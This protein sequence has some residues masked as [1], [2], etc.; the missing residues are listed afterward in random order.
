MTVSGTTTFSMTVSE[1]VTEARGLLGIQA[2]EEPL[3]AHELQQGIRTLNMMLKA[4]QADGVQAWTLT[5][6]TFTL[7]QA[8]ADYVFGAGGTFTTVPLDI[9]DVRITRNSN[10]I[11]MFRLSRED[12]YALPLRTNQGYPTQFYYDRQRE[13]GT[14]YVWPAP[15]SGLGTIDFTYRRYI[16][17]AGDGTNT[18]DLPTEWYEAITYNLADRLMPYYPGISPVSKQKVET[19]A[20]AAYF[21]VKGFDTGEGMGSISITPDWDS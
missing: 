3:E 4:W 20:A 10:S 8:D 16:M 18:L 7:V 12:Y 15:D 5:E 6:G 1:I 19:R 9:T 14:F 21:S 17:D 11:P 2:A 13:G